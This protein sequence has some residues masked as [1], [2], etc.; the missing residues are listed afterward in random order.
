MFKPEKLMFDYWRDTDEHYVVPPKNTTQ[1]VVSNTPFNA[2]TSI[3]D[4]VAVRGVDGE[5]VIDEG[6]V[7]RRWEMRKGSARG[8]GTLAAA[9][10][11]AQCLWAE[12]TEE[13]KS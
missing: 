7:L 12:L 3:E 1:V 5:P 2:Y 13:T 9:R 4:L 10:W 6:Q 8:H 11:I